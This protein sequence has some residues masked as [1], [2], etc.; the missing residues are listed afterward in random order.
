VTS[1]NREFNIKRLHRYLL[2]ARQGGV[3]PIIVLSKVD[4]AEDMASIETVLQGSFMGVCVIRASVP[5]H[6]GVD[7]IKKYLQAGK[8][9]VFIGS[10]GVGKSTL[11]NALMQQELQRTRAIRENDDHGRHTTSA[12]SLLFVPGGGMVIDTPGLREI[13]VFGDSDGLDE[14]F[15]NVH[16]FAEA[17]KFRDCTHNAEPGCAVRAALGSG[18]L[19]QAEYDSHMKLQREL[20]HANR[21]VDQRAAAKEKKRWKQVTTDMR[22]KKK[23]E[24]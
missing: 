1:A 16:R 6:I 15:E 11:V 19:A 8:T 9:T 17:C 18:E 22:K 12:S 24:E 3:E 21:Q 14:T 23:S 10:S 4:A 5:E 13:H 2:I 20:G 7:E